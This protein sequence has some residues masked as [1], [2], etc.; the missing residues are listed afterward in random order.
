MKKA[1][2]YKVGMNLAGYKNQTG[3][4]CCANCQFG[5]YLGYAD[6]PCRMCICE[7]NGECE[8]SD[9]AAIAVE[10]LAICKAYKPTLNS[11]FGKDEDE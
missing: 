10:P 11:N 5:G 8:D 7:I 6:D 1:K 4:P 2:E 9:Y 3:I